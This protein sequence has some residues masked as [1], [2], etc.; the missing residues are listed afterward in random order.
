[1]RLRIVPKIVLAVSTV[2]T[3]SAGLVYASVSGNVDV[4][5]LSPRLAALGLTL[6]S[7]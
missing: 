5:P 1:M 7:G 6:N 2:L 3:L 4:R